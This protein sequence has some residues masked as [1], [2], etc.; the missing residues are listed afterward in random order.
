[1]NLQKSTDCSFFTPYSE[2]RGLVGRFG[3]TRKFRSSQSI[4]YILWKGGP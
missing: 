4:H 2:R 3:E 1:M